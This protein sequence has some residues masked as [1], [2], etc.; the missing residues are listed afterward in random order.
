MSDDGMQVFLITAVK[1]VKKF[2]NHRSAVAVAKNNGEQKVGPRHKDVLD[3]VLMLFSTLS[4]VSW[5]RRCQDYILIWNQQCYRDEIEGMLLFWELPLP[6]DQFL[7]PHRWAYIQ[8]R[9]FKGK[10]EFL[11]S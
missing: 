6:F 11:V 8:F 10:I 9:F 1:V 4:Q 2:F 3:R 5:K 7:L